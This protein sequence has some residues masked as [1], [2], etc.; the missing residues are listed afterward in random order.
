MAK[1]IE[2]P[3]DSCSSL[4]ATNTTVRILNDG[5]LWASVIKYSDP[6]IYM[7]S[8]RVPLGLLYELAEQG[9]T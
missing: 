7:E 9:V 2:D 4:D 8:M 6:P 5:V 3:R 1:L